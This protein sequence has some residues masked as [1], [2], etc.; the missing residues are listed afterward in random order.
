[1]TV[2]GM[3]IES[4]LFGDYNF[5][6]L[7]CAYCIGQHFGVDKNDI[8]RALGKYT[9][10]NN[11]SQIVRKGSNMVIM[12]AYNANPSSMQLAVKSFADIPAIKKV[13]ILGDMLELGEESREEHLKLARQVISEGFDKVILVGDIFSAIQVHGAETYNKVEDLNHA[14]EEQEIKN[15]SVLIKGSR[16]IQLE[17]VLDSLSA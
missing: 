13:V 12:D 7:L 3:E 9:P 6:N 10:G 16:G 8:S 17:K 11:R 1:M 14:L 4:Q 15:A 5:M 2:E